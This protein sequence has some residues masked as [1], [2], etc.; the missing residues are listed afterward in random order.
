MPP[1]Y[2]LEIWHN[3]I[4]STVKIWHFYNLSIISA[5]TIFDQ[6]DFLDCLW[7]VSILSSLYS[8]LSGCISSTIKYH[9]MKKLNKCI[10]KIFKKVGSRSS[11]ICIICME[12]L[13]N[14][15]EL[16]PCGHT[17]HYKCF[18]QWVQTKEECPVCR[19]RINLNL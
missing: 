6:A 19:I 14:C 18:L 10:D 9:S 8:S 5:K 13:L 3:F 17:F 7:I 11:E 15:H 12:P 2:R 4:A 16:S 1:T